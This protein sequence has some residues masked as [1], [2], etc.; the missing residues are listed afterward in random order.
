MEISASNN[1]AKDGFSLTLREGT[2]NGAIVLDPSAEVAMA[3]TP[4]KAEVN[5]ANAFAQDAPADYEWID[6]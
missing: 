2:L 1:D 4:D 6:N 5:K 3:S